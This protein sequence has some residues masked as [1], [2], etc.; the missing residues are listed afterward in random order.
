MSSKSAPSSSFSLTRSRPSSDNLTIKGSFGACP[1]MVGKIS[2]PLTTVESRGS[3]FSVELARKNNAAAIPIPNAKRTAN[4][5]Q[6]QASSTDEVTGRRPLFAYLFGYQP[7][8]HHH[9]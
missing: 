2:C 5:Q 8:H 9:W 7:A 3:G 6:P 4:Q 1:V